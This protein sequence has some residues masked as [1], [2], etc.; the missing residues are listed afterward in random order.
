MSAKPM[1]API[2]WSRDH[3]RSRS[4]AIPVFLHRRFR[5]GFVFVNAAAG[6]Q[7]AEGPH[8]QEGR[9][10]QFPARRQHLDARHSGRAVRPAAPAGHLDGRAQ[11]GRRLH[12]AEGPS[13]RDDRVRQSSSTSCWRRAKSRPCCRPSCRGLSS[14]ATNGSRACFPTTRT[15]ELA[16]FRKTGIFPIMHVTTIKQ[17]IV[18]KYPWVPT[19]LVKAF[20]QAKKHRL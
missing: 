17:E 19:N 15:V 12:A 20:E 1:S 14:T 9:R 11:R 5:H 7:R 8:R 2:S 18:D 3:G 6:I 13:H 16:Y 10:H 4:P